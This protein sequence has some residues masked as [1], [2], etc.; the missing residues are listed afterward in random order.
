MSCAATEILDP[1]QPE[2]PRLRLVASP[3]ERAA[4][5]RRIGRYEILEAIGWGGFSVVYKAYD[6]LY[7]RSVAIKVCDR[8]DSEARERLR[9]EAAIGKFLTHRNLTAV[10]D[11]STGDSGLH[12]VQEYLPGEDLADMIR[13][14]EPRS[15]ARKLD[16]LTQ[17][18]SGLACAHSHGVIHRDV[19]P[20]NI[21]ILESGQVKIM[22]FGSAKRPQVDGKLTEIGMIVGTLAYLP[23]ECINGQPSRACS[24]IFAFGVLAYELLT[25]R[26]PFDSK[27]LPELID[28]VLT[29]NPTLTDCPPEV[30]RTIH[31]CLHKEPADRWPSFTDLE[32]NLERTL[33]RRAAVPGPPFPGE[34]ARA[35]TRAAGR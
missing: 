9:R 31:K 32:R 27:R 11:F 35:F 18:A 15:L 26:R 20:S 8:H 33:A 10:Y 30:A 1:K 19:K 2:G 22:D 24:D 3:P 12:L 25:F 6:P 17:V 23:P 21:R 34:S 13:R 5:A 29:S 14:R 7:R 4:Q 28:Q 16:I